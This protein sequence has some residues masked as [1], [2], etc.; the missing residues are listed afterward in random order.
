M[1]LILVQLREKIADKYIKVFGL[2]Q[3]KEKKN[4]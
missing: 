1:I 4:Y 2:Y 3:T